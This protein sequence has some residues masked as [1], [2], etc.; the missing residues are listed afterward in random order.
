[1]AKLIDELESILDR[2]PNPIL[3]V[4]RDHRLLAMNAN[5]K[6]LFGTRLKNLG[7][8]AVFRLPEPRNCVLAALNGSTDLES[9]ECRLIVA[10]EASDTVFKLTSKPLLPCECGLD[11][12]VV[13]LCDMS[14]LDR[15]DRMRR[16]FITNLSHELRSPITSIAGFVEILRKG[17]WE[18]E[19]DRNRYLD[20]VATE[21][22][23]MT[24]LLNDFLALS[25]IESREK[26]RP[27]SSVDLVAVVQD[28]IAALSQFEQHRGA[29]IRFRTGPRKCEIVG[30]GEQLRQVFGNII[31]NA[32]KYGGEG[33]RVDVIVSRQQST[34]EIGMPSV[35]VEIS[36]RGTGFD[37]IYIPRLTER[38][39][40]ID[41]ARNRESTGTGLGLA[42]VKHALNRHGGKLL[43]ESTPGVGS[44]FTV[45]LPECSSKSRT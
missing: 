24:K 14:E 22:G 33:N 2:I 44:K 13:S 9:T 39:F 28:S 25:S 45:L 31:E 38:F 43:I 1:M 36:D 5:A 10:G 6:S 12:A 18:T 32:I 3:I 23:R 34:P 29:N 37:P 20:I 7:F 30:D 11:G 8:E 16:D 21:S 40:R 15:N 4:G 26:V 19:S 17:A 42:I 35:K 27:T 41:H